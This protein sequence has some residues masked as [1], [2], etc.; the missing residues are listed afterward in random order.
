[1]GVGVF[2]VTGWIVWAMYR[3]DNDEDE[4]IYN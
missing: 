3:K 2:C 1:M 4:Q